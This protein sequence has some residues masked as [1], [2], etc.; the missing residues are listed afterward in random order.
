M[1]LD[2]L[3]RALQAEQHLP[4]WPEYGALLLN[5][6]NVVDTME[7]VASADPFGQPSL[8]VQLAAAKS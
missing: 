6:R 8:P 4:R 1:E 3:V 2:A 7:D 5:L